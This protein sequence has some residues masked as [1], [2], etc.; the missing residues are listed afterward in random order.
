[1]GKYVLRRMLASFVSI[2]VLVTVTFFLMHAI[3]GGP[4]SPGEQKDVPPEILNA[5]AE[6]YGLNDPIIEQYAKYLKRLATGDLGVS[7]VQRDVT[8]NE[9]IVAS[10]PTTF[11]LGSVTL[12][13]SLL[14]GVP[15]GVISAVRKDKFIDWFSRTFSTVGISVPNFVIAVLLL[16]TFTVRYQW[17]PSIG[18][19]SWRHFV[20]PVLALSLSPIAYIS[21][22]TR[23]EMIG[24]MK[25]DYIRTA[26][27]KGVGERSVILKH[28]LRNSITAVVTYLG[29]LITN[30]LTGSF[31]LESIFSIPGLGRHFVSSIGD[32]DYSVVLGLTIFYGIV[33]LLANMF[34]DF[35]YGIVDP[36]VKIES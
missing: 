12:L 21:R 28:A 23:S 9:K 17:F 10:F 31:V 27:A 30:L 35:V 33:L 24:T 13:F 26:R 25:Q 16:Q 5:I 11:Q 6:K 4:F 19:T 22:I 8:V 29:P 18:L 1:M 20:L 32:R 34:V 3:P 14:V 7:F 2:F 15:L 36:R